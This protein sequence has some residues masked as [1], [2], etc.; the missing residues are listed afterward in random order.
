[1]FP[2]PICNYNVH[3]ILYWLN[4]DDPRGP[5]PENPAADPQFD[6]W[7][8]SVQ[9]WAAL[10][11][12]Q[13]SPFYNPNATS[14]FTSPVTNSSGP[15]ISITSPSSQR[16]Y[17][18]SETIAISIHSD[19]SLPLSKV[20]YFVN[21]AY[22][23]SS[24]HSPFSFTFTPDDLPSVQATNELRAEAYDNVLNRGEA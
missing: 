18:K 7:E 14:S 24:D 22:I 12:Y 19:S 3:E 23:G 16:T 10:Q 21:G 1:G 5:P 20:D 8:A 6:N 2:S 9:R 11:G 15:R 4:K 13:S 17:G